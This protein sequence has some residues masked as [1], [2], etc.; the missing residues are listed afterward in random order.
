MVDVPNVLNQAADDPRL[1][2]SEPFRAVHFVFGL[3]YP[4]VRPLSGRAVL[5]SL[6]ALGYSDEA[7]RGILL[8]LRRGGFL[9]SARS[10]RTAAY[11]LSPRS[12]ALV[13]EISRRAALAPPPWTGAASVLIVQIPPAERA[14]R[15]QLRRHAAYAGVGT[16]TPGLLLATDPAA[17]EALEPLLS[18]AP[19]GVTVVRGTLSLSI[20]DAR[21]LAGAAW[22]LEPL[23]A[24]LREEAARMDAAAEEA[25]AAPPS[26]ATALAFLWRSI[27]PFFE[28]LSEGR[29]LPPELLPDD[30][31]LADAN[32]AFVKVALL[33]APL[34]L[35]YVERLAAAR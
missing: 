2:L 10:G 35:E 14:F 18:R 4:E 8:R 27:G 20:E 22:R 16:P 1:L 17:V 13:G 32:R 31:P 23:A 25:D 11:T 5:G 33:V 19:N 15:E 24:R 30:W 6:A 9:T 7:A 21:R 28:L 12:L 29:P 3:T 26:G 34:A